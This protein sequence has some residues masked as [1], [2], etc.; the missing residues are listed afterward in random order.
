MS[1]NRDL[2]GD[3]TID[4]NEVRWYLAGVDQYRAL[5]YGQNALDP[6]AYLIKSA[7]LAEINTAFG[8]DWGDDSN[9][10]SYR[11]KYHYFTCSGG[12]KTT[13]WPEEGLT[14]NPT[15][16]LEQDYWVSEA[17]LVRC[18]RTLVSNGTGLENPEKFYTYN[19]TTRT[20]N[21]G[22]IKSTRNY[23]EEPLE[24]HNEIEG[25]NNLYSGFVV[26]KNDLKNDQNSETFSFV[27]ITG[28]DTDYCSNY[29][30]QTN[31]NGE[32]QYSWR[33]PNQKEI[34]LMVSVSAISGGNYGTRTRFS[35]SDKSR[36]NR[37]WDWHNTPGFW[38]NTQQINV[39]TGYEDGLRIR[40]V[41]DKK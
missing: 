3:G 1:R 17:Q 38:T 29:K 10:H 19:A 16:S 11:S 41:R 34:A 12:N 4:G 39:G 14:N 22:G 24:I 23:T 5:F 21:L 15:R 2:D 30:N 28:N 8:G 35:G 33:T 37:Y 27:N 31:D 36:D 32:K 18:I 25:S 9:G 26:A 7:E 13:F 20:L 6:D 40:C